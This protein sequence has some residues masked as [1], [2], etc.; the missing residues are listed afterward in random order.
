MVRW[1]IWC[2]ALL[3]VLVLAVHRVLPALFT[4]DP[5][6]RDAV[7]AFTLQRLEVQDGQ[8]MF[9]VVVA[10]D[11]PEQLLGVADKLRTT[12]PGCNV[13]YVSLSDLI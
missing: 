4:S 9:R 8:V 3:G 13:S 6:V 11:S 10:P 2:G 5:A 1:G 7:G 12:M